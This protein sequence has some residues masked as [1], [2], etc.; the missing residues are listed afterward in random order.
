LPEPS[1]ISPFHK[2]NKQASNQVII[3]PSIPYEDQR[4]KKKTPMPFENR[5]SKCRIWQRPN[6]VAIRSTKN[7][8]IQP[9]HDGSH[10][11]VGYPV[12]AIHSVVQHDVA[13][14]KSQEDLKN[15]QA[16]HEKLSCTRLQNKSKQMPCMKTSNGRGIFLVSHL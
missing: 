15:K 6:T 14:E 12:A 5:K 3:N 11:N 13:V 8:Y 16:K 1:H 10:V 7:P 9:F 2:P 4:K